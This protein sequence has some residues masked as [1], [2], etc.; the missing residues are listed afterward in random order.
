MTGD[1]LHLVI[2]GVV[3]RTSSDPSPPFE[4]RS[5]IVCEQPLPILVG[6]FCFLAAV[7]P[8]RH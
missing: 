7:Q 3:L 5:F 1:I 6:A 4:Y 8:A 2:A